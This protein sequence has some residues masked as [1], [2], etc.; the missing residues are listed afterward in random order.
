ML[1]ILFI[2]YRQLVSHDVIPRLVSGRHYIDQLGW[3]FTYL[4]VNCCSSLQQFFIHDQLLETST[5]E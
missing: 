5:T 3:L 2:V 1:T 4:Y